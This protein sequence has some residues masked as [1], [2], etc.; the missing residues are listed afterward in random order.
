MALV[1]AFSALVFGLAAVPGGPVSAQSRGERAVEQRCFEH[2][3]FGAEPVDVAKSADGQTVLAQVSWGYHDSIGCFL[4]LDPLA[5]EVLR[6][7]PAPQRLPDASTGA[8]TRCFAHHRF[9]ERPVDVAKAADRQTVLAR[10]SWGY[11][12][13][14]GCFLVLD[15]TALATLRAALTDTEQADPVV[16]PEPGDRAVLVQQ[17]VGDSGAVV[18]QGQVSVSVPEGAISGRAEVVVREPLGEFGDEVGGEVVGVE[19]SGPVLEPVTVV[20]D[21]SHLSEAEQQF[22]VLV[23]WDEDLGDWLPG[24]ADFEIS[25]G[26]LTARIGEWSFWTWIANASQTIQ[27]LFGRRIDAPQCSGGALHGWVSQTTEPDEVTNAAS[28]RMCYENGPD[29][30]I[31]VRL[32]NNRVFSQMV[33]IKG[34]YGLWDADLKGDV[35]V[36]GLVEE[37]VH[38]LLTVE[39]EEATVFLPPLRYVDVVIQRPSRAGV[40][41]ISFRNEVNAATIVS[42]G[43]IYLSGE[44]ASALGKRANPVLQAALEI[45][46]ECGGPQ[47]AAIAQSTGIKRSLQIALGVLKSCVPK[48]ADPKSDLGRRFRQKVAE[49]VAGSVA[50]QIEDLS[51]KLG[52]AVRILKIVELVGY[53]A[54]LAVEG[55]TGTLHWNI[56]GQGRIRDLGDWTPTCAHPDQDSNRLLRH[57]VWREPFTRSGSTMAAEG[58]HRFDEWEP[59]AEKAVAPLEIC[60]DGHNTA[61]AAEVADWFGGDEPAASGIVSNLI[62]GLV[63]AD[64]AGGY[65][66]V[67]AGKA[68]SCAITVEGAVA[69]WGDDTHRQ[70]HE[71]AGRYT[72]VSAGSGHTCGLRVDQAIVCWG[73]DDHGKTEA[74]TGRYTAVDAG[75]EHTCGLRVDQAIACWGLNRRGQSDAPA[76]RFTAVSVGTLHTCGLRVDQTISCWGY[77]D[78]GETSPPSGRYTAVEAGTLHTCGLRVD[79]TPVCWGGSSGTIPPGG[80]ISLSKFPSGGH[81]CGLRAGQAIACWGSGFDGQADPPQGAY[82]AVSAGERHTCAL[83]QART[84]E[85]WG[86]NDRGQT[87]APS[88]TTT[89][90]TAP[91]AAGDSHSCAITADQA[92]SCWGL[93]DRGQADPPPGAHTAIAAGGHHTCAIAAD[94]A[95]SCWGLNDRGQA[96]P[97]PGAYTVIAAGDSHSCAITT[98]GKA[99][100]WGRNNEGQTVPPDGTY[101]AI[102]AGREHTCAITTQQ[103]AKCWGQNDHGQT[104]DRFSSLRTLTRITAAQNQTCAITATKTISCWGQNDHNQATGSIFGVYTA[105]TS[106]GWHWCALT[107]QQLIQCAGRN[108]RGQTDAPPGTYTHIAAGRKHT[109]ATKTDHT[110][111]CWGDNTHGQASPQQTPATP[112]ATPNTI[113]VGSVHS[114]GIRAD[115]TA[116]CWGSNA[117]GQ[118]DAPAGRFTSIAV[119]NAHSCGIRA[120]GTAACW[121]SNAEGQSDAPAG[122]FTSIA[123]SNAHSCGIRADGT[124]ACWGYNAEGQSDAPAGRFTSI[125]AGAWHSCG[126]RADGTAACWGY[127]IYGRSDAPAGRFT[128]IAVGAWHSCGIR[129]DSTAACWG[130]NR[131]GE[132]DAPAGRFTSIAVGNAHSCGIRA[133]STAACWGYNRYGQS[134]APAGRFTSIAV[135]NAHSCGIRVD[136]TAACWGYNAEGQSDAPAGRFTSIAVGNAHSCGI[137][138]DGTA[139][140]WGYNRYGQSDAPAGRFAVGS[141]G[142]GAGAVVLSKG[143]SAQG[144]TG[145]STAPCRHLRIEFGEGFAPGPLSVECWSSRDPAAP[146]YSGTWQWPSS[147]LWT[148]GGCWFGYPGEQ[149]W[150]VVDGIKS[151]VVVW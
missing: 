94:Q 143:A 21:V 60:G 22:V 147:S 72:A 39:G 145:C 115:G 27:E 16:I 107:T 43:F 25:G 48:I 142:A 125:A 45:L 19:H 99:K 79:R 131:Y 38:Q 128:S 148:E 70:I 103:K 111:T 18:S 149:V 88:N 101:T 32:A 102:A 23:R 50:D 44:A 12:D 84:I 114:C 85:C 96:D 106:G 33:Y 28:I 113:A 130:Y 59:S 77:D 64:P 47:V 61:V 20:W 139:A 86:N 29:E 112:A 30:S 52:T 90:A 91:I 75:V 73:L 104:V 76:G 69:C 49:N 105:I 8:S 127:N 133:D 17:E 24:D 123:V 57:L 31:R 10:L 146:W 66:A 138:A 26:T 53:L 109:C 144:K 80:L 6:A 15:D 95:I 58:L 135:G 118:S 5:L 120:D 4:T 150:V 93:N 11:H 68:H 82:A 3:G 42:D 41:N 37:A 117:E 65:T 83:T 140:C 36:G 2:H 98:R 100:C 89:P 67:A 40:H 121:G 136:G 78:S 55:I 108:N 116:A 122:R 1:V 119:S 14:I 71:P 97:P 34:S 46:F 110:I 74:P 126:I 62:L 132:S 124:A 63:A 56:R 141:A 9:G 54:D 51:S 129:A 13:S 81:T 92:I 134:D 87:D 137:R 35:S 7:V 151:N